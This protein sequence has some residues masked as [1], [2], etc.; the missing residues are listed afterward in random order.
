MSELTY[1][2]DAIRGDIEDLNSSADIQQERLD[3]IERAIYALANG[4]H[5]P[6]AAASYAKS[7]LNETA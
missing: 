2:V 1:D 3:R 7:V 6:F 4:A 5:E